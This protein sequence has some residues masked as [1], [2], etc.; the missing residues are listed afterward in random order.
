M[1]ITILWLSVFGG[2]A[3]WATLIHLNWSRLR[4]SGGVDALFTFLAAIHVFRFIG[5]AALVPTHVDGEVFGFTQTYLAQ[6]GYGDYIAGL[7][8]CLALMAT[9]GQWP[10]KRALQ[11]LFVVV[12]TVDTINAGPQFILAITDQN[13]VGALGWLILTIYVPA[14]IVT[15]TLLVLLM[16]GKVGRMADAPQKMMAA[17]A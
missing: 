8:A 17:R 10:A 9:K 3:A 13:N 2:I 7:L 12:G 5:L 6:V 15:E 1:N 11:W 4:D 16:L 14:L